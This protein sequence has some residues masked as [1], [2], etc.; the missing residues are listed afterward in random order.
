MSTMNPV[1]LISFP[2][3]PYFIGTF[4]TTRFKIWWRSE[5]FPEAIQQIRK[6]M[7]IYGRSHLAI[8]QRTDGLWAVYRSK[9]YGIAWERVWLAAEGE[10]I[11]DIVLITFGRAIMNTSTGFYETV[12]A[13]TSWSKVADLPD[14]PNAPAF[15]NVGNGDVLFCTDGRY[16]WSSADIARSW[17]M[18]C[19]QQAISHGGRT[20]TG[21]SYPTIAGSCGQIVCAHGPFLT[22]SPDGGT[23]WLSHKYWDMYRSGSPPRS[24]VY[25]RLPSNSK[26]SFLIKQLLLSSIDGPTPADVAMLLQSDDL[27][28]MDKDGLLYSRT[29]KSTWIP[30]PGLGQSWKYM[31]QQLITPTESL[32]QLMG[33]DLPVTGQPYNDRLAFSAQTRLDSSGQQV[34]SLKYSLDGGATWI[35]I[36]LQGIRMGTPEGVPVAGGSMLDENFAHITWGH[37][38]CDNAGWWWQ[39]SEIDRRQCQSFE[40]DVLIDGQGLKD[41]SI[42]A[43]V[44][45][46]NSKSQSIDLLNERTNSQ[47]Q[48]ADAELEG[49]ASH[50]LKCDRLLEGIGTRPQQ[51]DAV[52]S[53]AIDVPL[54][55]DAGLWGN[56]RFRQR[57]DGLL[58]M[59]LSAPQLC[60]VVLV[61]F[62]LGER[63]AKIERTFPQVF[64]L[65]IPHVPTG[66][67][68][69]RKE[70][71]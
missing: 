21:P 33:Y 15:C 60:D 18:V 20:Y 11:Y 5:P 38:W 10:E 44:S 66:P 34:P 23:T 22:I 12:K 39:F 9:N 37:G 50:L 56:K 24:V 26:P 8:A 16:I 41:Q 61:H 19:D 70:T 14:A 7:H 28:P 42:D 35:D 53:S 59:K 58:Q 51:H 1:V 48:A 67:Y 57:T 13:G 40:Q 29:F 2:N 52:F 64:D 3:L 31:F 46:N 43:I 32:Q 4:D 27:L 68:D 45:R 62:K 25:D 69:S 65:D 47:V 71:L 30:A 17:T 49:R 63:L 6:G 36:D 55:I 54:E